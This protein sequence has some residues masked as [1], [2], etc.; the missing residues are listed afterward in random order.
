MSD[1]QIT[2]IPVDENGR[3]IG[4]PK[5]ASL[6]CFYLVNLEISHRF[7]SSV[8]QLMFDYVDVCVCFR[9]RMR[10]TRHVTLFV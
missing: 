10:S 8:V 4:M 9:C 7:D 1:L 5:V 2:E 6:L 3:S